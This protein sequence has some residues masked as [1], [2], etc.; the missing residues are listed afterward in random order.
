MKAVRVDQNIPIPPNAASRPEKYPMSALRTGDSFFFPSRKPG[1][2]HSRAKSLG[3]TI[4][5]RFV[6]ENGVKGTRVWRTA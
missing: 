2:F 3:I 6:V 1:G 5:T 4:T